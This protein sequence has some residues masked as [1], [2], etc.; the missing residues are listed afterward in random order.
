M[1]FREDLSESNADINE[2]LSRLVASSEGN[3]AARID[4]WVHN[5]PSGAQTEMQ[6]SIGAQV[7][8][9]PTDTLEAQ[10]TPQSF[11]VEIFASAP[12]ADQPRIPEVNP[13]TFTQK[14]TIQNQ[15]LLPPPPPSVLFNPSL[16]VPV[17]H[18]LPN[19]SAWTISTALNNHSTQ[20]SLPLPSSQL[21]QVT[22]T[23]ATSSSAPAQPVSV[24]PVT[25][26]ETVYYVPHLV[27]TTPA[28]GGTTTQPSSWLTRV[29]AAPFVSPSLNA[30]PPTSSASLP[31]SE[32]AHLIA[33]NK[34]DHLPE[35]NLS[36]Y[37]GDPVQWHEWFETVQERN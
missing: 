5:S 36:Q 27:V 19:M 4:D 33:S 29:S 14:S 9:A 28:V 7:T 31:I 24:M 30:A 16:T 13:T 25:C 23:N 8:I 34:K 21:I 17:S 37:S 26:R 32:V 12:A 18:I 6:P 35:I 15:V 2:S 3:E 10:P 22:T 1:E 20:P 11:P